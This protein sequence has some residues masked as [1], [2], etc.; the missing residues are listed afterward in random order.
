MLV[1]REALLLVPLLL[2]AC[3]QP[4]GCPTEEPPRIQGDED[5]ERVIRG[6]MQNWVN[7]TGINMCVT[8]VTLSEVRKRW[9]YR[10]TVD[11]AKDLGAEVFHAM[12]TLADTEG[13]ISSQ[14]PDLFDGIGIDE[15]EWTTPE[16]R[17]R[18]DFARTCERSTQPAKSWYALAA[19]TCDEE[20]AHPEDLFVT[21]FFGNSSQS[22]EFGERVRTNIG[23]IEID[24]PSPR[25]AW[26]TANQIL[27]HTV[28]Y[29][30]ELWTWT[31]LSIDRATLTE[32]WRHRI[33]PITM[34]PELIA[35]PGLDSL[36]V[37]QTDTG[38][39]WLAS[40]TLESVAPLDDV[41][42]LV[43][44]AEDSEGWWCLTSA[45]TLQA[46]SPELGLE[47]AHDVPSSQGLYTAHDH[48]WRRGDNLVQHSTDRRIRKPTLGHMSSFVD[49][50]AIA[51]SSVGRDTTVALRRSLDG[52]AWVVEHVHCPRDWDYTTGMV[53]SS[54]RLRIAT[55][56]HEPTTV[57]FWEVTVP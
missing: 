27:L 7:W 21:E 25:G 16:D 36:L 55:T 1:S 43:S 49:D 12:C 18:E 6:Y 33:T 41:G 52:D 42:T 24:L 23:S 57:T 34:S 17:N 50:M 2:C 45:R 40:D 35:F 8:D 3:A 30:D 56:A 15:T 19:T 20:P 31:L 51:F 10:F 4:E 28:E 37:V 5:Q 11:P 47:E 38:E 22:L 46:Y 32:Q 39:A 26:S 44:C 14:Y 48:H 54:G 29:E 13:A 9:R 53:S